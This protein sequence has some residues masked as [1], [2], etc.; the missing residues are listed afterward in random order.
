MQGERLKEER[1]RLSIKQKELASWIG[2]TP[3]TLLKYEKNTLGISVNLLNK[4]ASRGFD[5]QYIVTG[6]R[7]DS[8]Y[9]DDEKELLEL[10][11]NAQSSLQVGAKAMLASGQRESQV[12][13]INE[14]VGGHVNIGGTQKITTKL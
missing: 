6:V 10:Y 8:A 13:N 2:C 4:L 12:I 9:S 3:Q 1:K 7:S 14:K 5:I 11:R